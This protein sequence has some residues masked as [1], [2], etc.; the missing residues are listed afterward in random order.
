MIELTTV[1]CYC[2]LITIIK[3]ILITLIKTKIVVIKIPLVKSIDKCSL[4]WFEWQNGFILQLF[5][6]IC[7]NQQINV[8]SV[9]STN[10]N[11]L[12][13]ELFFQICW[14][15]QKIVDSVLIRT[16]FSCSGYDA[17]GLPIHLTL[18]MRLFI[19]HFTPP[20]SRD[21]T[22]HLLGD[23]SLKQSTL[24]VKWRPMGQQSFE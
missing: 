18:F 1:I 7:W 16:A 8:H 22:T 3:I 12:I 11:I 23:F 5:S 21:L 4:C 20:L 2:K 24:N 13:S 14:N 10:T 19:C 15:Q 6:R 17:D 9:D